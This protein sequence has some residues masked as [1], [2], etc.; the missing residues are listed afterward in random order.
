MNNKNI[1]NK[2]NLQ[3]FRLLLILFLYPIL[4]APAQA[5]AIGLD[6]QPTLVIGQ[7]SQ[8]ISDFI[9]RLSNSKSA[10]DW[11]YPDG[12][13]VYTAINDPRGLS[14]PAD[15]GAGINHA[16][17]ILRKFP[18]MQVVQIGLYLKYMLTE[19]VNGGLDENIDKLG[20]WIKDSKKDVYLRIGY[21]FDNPD[22]EY[23]PAEY[24]KAYRY[25]VDRLREFGVN[26]VHY[27]WHTI[28][29]KDKTWP[30]YNPLAWYPGDEYVDWVGI[31]FFDSKRDKER[32]LAVKIAHAKK[33]P[34][35]IAE[36]SPFN[37]Y[38]VEEKSEW[39]NQLF[40]FI[41]QNH[42]KFISY[43]NVNW[44]DLLLFKAMKWGDAR[45]QKH[46]ELLEQWL[47]HIEKFRRTGQRE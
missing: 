33:K 10:Q 20:K 13:M 24:V 34:L 36:S 18:K 15:H 1:Q 4:S 29:W 43:I 40:E 31:S 2:I 11:F 30:G 17:D 27:V 19:I 47:R 26:T 38:S 3:T 37:Q 9:N 42:I 12:I 7:D 5:A 16:D 25:I 22:N 35:M 39:L 44:D 28:A 32:R 21:E 14:E 6:N 45:L 8:S 41:S 23:A 46:P